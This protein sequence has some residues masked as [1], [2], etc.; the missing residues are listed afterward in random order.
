MQIKKYSSKF[1]F[2]FSRKF[3]YKTGLRSCLLYITASCYFIPYTCWQCFFH[4]IGIGSRWWSGGTDITSEGTFYW[5]H[6]LEPLGFTK[7]NPGD[8][9]GGTA[10]NCVLLLYSNR[11]QDFPCYDNNNFICEKWEYGHVHTTS[12][13]SIISLRYLDSRYVD[14]CNRFTKRT[15]VYTY[16]KASLSSPLPTKSKETLGL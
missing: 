11:W 9:S 5:H 8:P 3:F 2:G 16:K 13:F 15:F 12:L 4:D 10:E 7:W 6:S 14:K 1:I